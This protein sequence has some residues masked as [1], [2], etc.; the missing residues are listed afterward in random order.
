MGVWRGISLAALSALSASAL[1]PN[2]DEC[3]LLIYLCTCLSDWPEGMGDTV[4]L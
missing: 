2:G 1:K 4:D 3:F